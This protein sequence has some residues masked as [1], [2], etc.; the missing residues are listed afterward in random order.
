MYL[1][2]RNFSYWDMNDF[3]GAIYFGIKTLTSSYKITKK[4]YNFKLNEMGRVQCITISAL[5]FASNVNMN[6]A[7][8]NQLLRFQ[9]IMHCCLTLKVFL[10]YQNVVFVLINIFHYPCCNTQNGSAFI[11]FYID[12]SAIILV[13]TFHWSL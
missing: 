5:V 9:W 2:I 6:W 10:D 8:D 13:Q 11:L 3:G 7:N 12:P 4:F 1:L